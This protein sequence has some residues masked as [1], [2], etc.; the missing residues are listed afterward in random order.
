MEGGSGGR[1]AMCEAS[2]GMGWE[3]DEIDVVGVHE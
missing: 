2:G 3:M 1:G